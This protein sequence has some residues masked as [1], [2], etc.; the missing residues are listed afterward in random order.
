MVNVGRAAKAVGTGTRLVVK[1]GP[2]AKIAWDNGGRKAAEATARRARSLT[3]RRKAFTHAA[4]V[5]DGAVLRIAP[6][7]S[8]A[9]AVLSGDQPVA[10]YPPQEESLDTLLAHADLSRREL[11]RE[12]GRPA[13]RGRSR[14]D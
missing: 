6:G 8:T 12:P 2:Q 9:Y 10:V 3:A 11:P 1:Y 5:V 14:G 7:G 4:T 13:L